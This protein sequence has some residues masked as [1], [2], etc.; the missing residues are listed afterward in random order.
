MKYLLPILFLL[1]TLTYAQR[2]QIGA[3]AGANKNARPMG[4]GRMNSYSTEQHGS[5]Y[6]LCYGAQLKFK[7][8]G[9]WQ[10]GAMMEA[11]EIS[12]VEK[13]TDITNTKF[14]YKYIIGGPAASVKCVVNTRE[15]LGNFAVLCGLTAGYTV[16]L[17]GKYTKGSDKHNVYGVSIHGFSA[18]LL[19]GIEYCLS[20]SISLGITGQAEYLSYSLGHHTGTQIL[21]FP[22]VLG[23]NYNIGD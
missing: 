9:S 20:E 7:L 13:G 6:N 5:D 8:G 11:K 3:Y 17:P 22:V 18:G 16:A 19:A 14:R 21:T 1:P 15:M 12:F 23:I 10:I 2:L 4:Y